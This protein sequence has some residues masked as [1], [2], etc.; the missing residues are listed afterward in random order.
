MAGRIPRQF[1][2]DLAARSDIVEVIS[3]RVQL[4]KKGKDFWGLCPFH[5]EKSPSFSVSPDKQF[6]YCFGCGAS[7]N[8]LSFL[9]E[10]DHLDFVESVETLARMQGLEVPREEGVQTSAAREQERQAKEKQLGQVRA[11][12]LATEFFQQQLSRSEGLEGLTYLK[13]KRGLGEAVMQSFALG[14]AP[15]AWDALKNH[16]SQAG[17]PEAQQLELGLLAQKEETGRVYDR[18]RNRVIFPIR[19]L[20][21]QV[22]AFGGR[23]LD[24]SKPK[25][26]NSPETPL[27]HKGQELYGLYEARKQAGRLERLLVVEGYMDVVAL[28]QQGIHWSVATLGTATTGDHLKRVFR[29]VNE[30]VFCFDGDNAGQQAAHKALETVLPWMVD[31]RQARFLFLPQG[32]DP[33]T[34]VRKEGAGLFEQRVNQALPLGEF[35]LRSLRTGL[36]LNQVDG[37]TRLA[38]LA[39]PKLQALPEGFLKKR[40]LIS[41]ARLTGFDEA[42]LLPGSPGSVEAAAAKR[43]PLSRP[44]A[45]SHQGQLGGPQEKL[46]RLLV[47]FPDL[48]QEVPA[49]LDFSHSDEQQAQYFRNI[50]DYLHKNPGIT[51][52][53]LLAYWTGTPEG[54]ALLIQARQVLEL[55]RQAAEQEIRH[56]CKQL[57]T[58]HTQL[59]RDQRYREL[60][61]ASNQRE[62]TADEHQELAELMKLLPPS[63][64]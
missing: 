50:L 58:S 41:L 45:P 56:I 7:G 61:D 54:E 53:V 31:G 11:M 30:V 5:N 26:L 29:L 20:Q 43:A 64:W 32:E 18:F 46:F 16:L 3:S 9:M 33:D 38:E 10:H 24:D 4:K 62:L 37:Q 63:N 51:T 19:N 21:G 36:D 34:L 27:F 55:N 47:R 42:S 2:D 59:G 22:I 1:I 35:L 40:L 28:A 57:E 25:Y 17:I 60:L 23:V 13:D 6:Y 14:V 44:A 52:Q 12:Q 49:N 15:D 8:A 48:A 39:R